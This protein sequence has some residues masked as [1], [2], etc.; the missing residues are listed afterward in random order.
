M[1]LRRWAATS[2]VMAAVAWAFA[3]L[4]PDSG[5]AWLA[6]TSPQALVDAAGVDALLVPIAAAAGWACWAWGALGLALTALSALPGAAGRTAD[7]L[8]VAL[9]PAGARR[10]AALAVGLAV[11]TGAAV[12]ALSTTLP[13]EG[14]AAT[15]T[16]AADHR[17][18]PIGGPVADWPAGRAEDPPGQTG[19][20]EPIGIPPDWPGPPTS[21]T[22]TADQHVVVRGDCL[23][24][25]AARWLARQHPDAPVGDDDVLAAVHAWWQT[26]AVVIG[27][28]PDLLLP[29]Q[30]LSPPHPV[31][32]R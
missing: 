17:P 24:D 13:P 18:Q 4:G 2:A 28:D 30:V 15:L 10:L 5:R 20:D 27:P 11:G 32:P 1:S 22:S 31:P 25:I 26:N 19:D 8:L 6:V 23:W 14:A 29:G 9:L 7:L 3:G 21:T 16:T 12:P